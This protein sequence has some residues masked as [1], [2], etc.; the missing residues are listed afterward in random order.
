MLPFGLYKDDPNWVAPLIMDQYSLFNPQ[1]N[2][3][4]EHSEVQLYL[5]M[6]DDKVLGRISAHTNTQHQKEHNEDIGFFGFF[7]SESGRA[8]V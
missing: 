6:E 5:A 4:Y 3:Y 7:D 8:H 2:P 1:K